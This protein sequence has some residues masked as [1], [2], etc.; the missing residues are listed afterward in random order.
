MARVFVFYKQVALAPLA[1]FVLQISQLQAKMENL[2]KDK[3]E[4]FNQLKKVLQE[5][6]NKKRAQIKEQK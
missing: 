3:N 1:V 2:K 5:D 4:L 6:E